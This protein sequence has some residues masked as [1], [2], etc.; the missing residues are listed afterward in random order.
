[1]AL[2]ADGVAPGDL[3]KTLDTPAGLD[4]A[5][6]KLKALAPIWAHDSGDALDWVKNGQ[7]VMATALNGDVYDQSR[8]GFAPAVIWDQPAL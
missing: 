1:M 5:F 6:A 2:L 4:R 3:Y 7:A 8:L